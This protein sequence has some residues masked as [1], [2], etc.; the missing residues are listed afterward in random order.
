MGRE[1][2]MKVYGLRLKKTQEILGFETR[3]NDGCCD[4]NSTTTEL[5]LESW[6]SPAWLVRDRKVAEK[7]AITNVEWYNAGYLTPANEYAGECEAFE[8]LI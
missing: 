2:V 5:R 7:A 4:C 6:E 8:V 3:S 1:V